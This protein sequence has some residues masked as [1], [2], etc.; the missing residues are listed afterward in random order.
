MILLLFGAPGAGK[1][2]LAEMLTK[3]YKLPHVSTG[4]LLR[5]HLSKGTEIGRKAKEYMDAGL[6]VPDDVV[7]EI[8]EE[9]MDEKA[10]H[11]GYILDGF[12]RTVEQAEALD[13]MLEERGAKIAH[14]FN[15]DVPR[16]VIVKRLCSRRVCSKCGAIY[17]VE[18]KPPKKE[19]VCDCCGAPL[20]QRSDDT[21]EVI[22]KRLAEYESKTKPVLDY[23][24]EKGL[25]R[26]VKGTDSNE[27]FGK[28]VGI[29]GK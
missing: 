5:Y 27:L 8:L 17:N 20:M 1:G 12:P 25:V 23:Y 13:E 29:V 2:T 16:D 9:K 7:L 6:L 21:D 15:I 14:V 24:Q 26:T 18:F 19:G 10:C 11:G 28:I 3:H 22:R 4:D